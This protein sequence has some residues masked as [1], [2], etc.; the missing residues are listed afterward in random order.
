MRYNIDSKTP[1]NPTKKKG[2]KQM[3][4]I[5]KCEKCGAEFTDFNEAWAH[6]SKHTHPQDISH[7]DNTEAAELAEIYTAE[8]LD[9]DVV[10]L[11]VLE[12]DDDGAS[13]WRVVPYKRDTRHKLRAERIAALL[14]AEK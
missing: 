6:E 1:T 13:T 10:F 4:T 2:C 9:P 3:T 12:T 5:Y 7:W 14:N 11:K 8:S